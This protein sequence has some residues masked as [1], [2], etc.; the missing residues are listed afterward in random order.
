MFQGIQGQPATWIDRLV[1]EQA[2]VVAIWTGTPDP[3][4]IWE[5]EFFNRSVGAVY[6]T[7]DQL[8]PTSRESTRLET[9]PDGYLRDAQ[10]RTLRHR[11]V[12][13][14][15]S[16]DLNGTKVATEAP[17]GINLW[18]LRGPVRSL[19]RVDGLYPND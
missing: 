8:P 16:L 6:S 7:G 12:L 5:N 9:S 10:G 15:G 18:R 13:V 1:G 17:I 14:D 3:H 19:T 11:Y 2:D 4:V